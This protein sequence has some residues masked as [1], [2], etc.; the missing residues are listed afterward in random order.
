MFI[1]EVYCSGMLMK[2]VVDK[3][4]AKAV[5][6]GIG[7]LAGHGR[8]NIQRRH[9]LIVNRLGDK[10]SHHRIF[11]AV[12]HGFQS[13]Q[14]ARATLMCVLRQNAKLAFAKRSNVRRDDDARVSL[15]KWHPII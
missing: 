7:K 1:L 3:R 15:Q 11:Q 14:E 5:E 12:V 4:I 10:S 9:N 6:H 8:I 2:L 13:A